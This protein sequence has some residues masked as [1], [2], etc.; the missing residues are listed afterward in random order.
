MNPFGIGPAGAIFLTMFI[1]A[2]VFGCVWLVMETTVRVTSII[3]NT[4]ITVW[5]RIESI[6]NDIMGQKGAKS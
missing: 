5:Y 2:V 6:V 1:A 3:C 4:I